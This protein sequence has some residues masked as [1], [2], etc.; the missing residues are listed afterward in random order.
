MF[1]GISQPCTVCHIS[2]CANRTEKLV[3]LFDHMLIIIVSMSLYSTCLTPPENSTTCTDV[4]QQRRIADRCSVITDNNGVF[5]SCIDRL[6][7]MD[8]QLFYSSCLYDACQFNESSICLSLDVFALECFLHGVQVTWR[9]ATGCRK[10]FYAIILRTMT[11][12]N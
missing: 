2:R 7:L 10:F 9:N 4:T 11:H 6:G 5:G 1:Q 8:A 3:D 12:F